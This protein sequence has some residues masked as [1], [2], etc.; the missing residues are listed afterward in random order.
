M[1][2]GDLVKTVP[3]EW[4][5]PPEKFHVAVGVVVE[6]SRYKVVVQWLDDNKLGWMPQKY[7][8]VISESR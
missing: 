2:V 5:L 7:L 8:E 4:S 6:K 3:V 1:K